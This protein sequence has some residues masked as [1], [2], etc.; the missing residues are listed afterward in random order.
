MTKTKA[1]I[2]FYLASIVAFAAAIVG[3]RWL[4]TSQVNYLTTGGGELIAGGFELSQILPAFGIAFSAFV[5]VPCALIATVPILEKTRKLSEDISRT[6]RKWKLPVACSALTG[7]LVNSWDMAGIAYYNAAVKDL[8][9]WATIT[10]AT[11]TFI[12][13]AVSAASYVSVSLLGGVGITFLL[14]FFLL[15][16]EKS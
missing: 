3:L 7:V 2:L 6:I 8:P 15:E 9:A 11:N 10:L 12:E 14:A 1:A 16:S 13:R 5:I 4:T